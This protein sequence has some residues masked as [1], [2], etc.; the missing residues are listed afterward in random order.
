MLPKGLLKEYSHAI[1]FILRG[2]DMAAIVIAGLL[3]YYWKFNDL[4]LPDRYWVALFIAAILTPWIFRFFHIYE[5]IRGRGFVQHLRNLSQAI[6]TLLILLAGFAFFTKT[7]QDFS[8]SWFALWASFS[9]LFLM[10]FR[11]SLL[12]LL[13]IMRAHGMNE[14]RVIIIGSGELRD[15]LAGTVQQAEW[16]GFRIVTLLSDQDNEVNFISDYVAK[17]VIDEVWLVLP[18]SAEARIKAIMHELRHQTVTLRLVLD[19][20]GLDLLNHSVTNLAGFPVINIRSTPM[21][22]I[23]RIKKAIED[24]VLASIILLMISPIFLLIALLVKCSSAGPVFYKQKRV[25]W[26]GKEFDMLKFRTM[27]VNAEANT[28]PVWAK[29]NEN[30]ATPIGAFLRK[31]S[32]DELPQFIN[33]LRGD[34]SIVGPRPERLIF[35]EEFKDKIPGYMQKHLVKAGITGWAQVNGWRGNTSLE[36]RIEY[37]LYY[38]ENWSLLFDF[39]IIFLTLF[40]GFI[41]KNAY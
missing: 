6:A 12:L 32:L 18:L 36:K 13:R 24:R 39:K 1:S 8:R 15:K 26:N 41:H 37:D 14:R 25:S 19:I 28:G 20:F 38:I 23:N 17:N 2:L 27:P 11:S 34:M 21:V 9:F 35:V 40:Q 7:G 16:T 31:T 5:S 10:L 4:I 29:P 33:V 30:R 3:A 22:G